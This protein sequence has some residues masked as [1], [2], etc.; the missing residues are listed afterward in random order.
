[1]E[2]EGRGRIYEKWS[3]SEF[4]LKD[5]IDHTL[6]DGLDTRCEE[7]N[8]KVSKVLSETILL[9]NQGLLTDTVKVKG[10][11]VLRSKMEVKAI[12]T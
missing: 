12:Q 4:I 11:Q 1:M 9:V 5:L 8:E 10:E 7:K 6:A 2:Q 3:V